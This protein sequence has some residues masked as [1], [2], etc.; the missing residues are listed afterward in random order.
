MLIYVSHGFPQFVQAG[1]GQGD[2]RSLPKPFQTFSSITLPFD[3]TVQTL[4]VS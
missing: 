3:E 1:P 2:E 4:T